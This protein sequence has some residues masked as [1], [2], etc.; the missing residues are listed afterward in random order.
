M[1]ARLV[2]VGDSVASF[3]PIYGQGMSSA[4]LHASCLS[5]YLGTG[6]DIRVPAAGFFGLQQVV[7]DAAWAISAGG[8]AARLDALSGAEVPEEVSRQRQAM[9]Q[10]LRAACVDADVTRAVEDVTFMLAH[11]AALADPGLLDKAIAANQR[12]TS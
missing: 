4:A 5:Q 7:T 9:D 12:G 2:S 6:P 11:P 10:L 8:D 1:P 3:N